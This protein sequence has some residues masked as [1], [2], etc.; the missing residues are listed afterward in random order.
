MRSTII[1]TSEKNPRPLDCANILQVAFA[2]FF[3][4]TVILSL[5][6]ASSKKSR[7]FFFQLGPLP[8]TLPLRLLYLH[9]SREDFMTHHRVFLTSGIIVLTLLLLFC[10]GTNALAESSLS[11]ELPKRV[12]AAIRSLA[13]IS[14]DYDIK[15]ARKDQSIEEVVWAVKSANDP[16]RLYD[17]K[18]RYI[19]LRREN[20]VLVHTKVSRIGSVLTILAVDLSQL[21]DLWK[22]SSRYGLGKGLHAE[23]SA[24][25]I[26]V[27]STFRGVRNLVHMVERENPD[28]DLEPVKQTLI[29]LNDTAIRFFTQKHVDLDEQLRLVKQ[30]A[31][32]VQSVK[33][34]IESEE[35][36]LLGRWSQLQN[37]RIEELTRHAYPGN[38]DFSSRFKNYHEGW[39]QE[40]FERNRTNKL[41]SERRADISN[42]G[43][44]F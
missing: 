27:K 7:I 34:L 44:T 16:E 24:A 33:R 22:N 32:M 40:V 43:E 20:M 36:Y 10:V 14:Q 41:H 31:V 4:S 2:G 38:W 19:E 5:I 25:R 21:D 8:A 1:V 6:R 35:R 15:I 37:Q 30:W 13:T 9:R 18:S 39:D 12:R 26:A 17:L 23:D 3:G 29:H 11:V 28:A 42:V